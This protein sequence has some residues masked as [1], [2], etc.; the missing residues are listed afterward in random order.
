MDPLKEGGERS[1]LTATLSRRNAL[2]AGAW[3]TP[4]VAAALAV[5]LAAASNDF[6]LTTDL[7]VRAAG[8]AEGRYSTSADY[9]SGSVAPNND[10]RRA[11]SVQNTGMGTFTGTL[12]VSFQFPRMWNNFGVGNGDAFNN[13]GTVDLGSSGGAGVGGAS[14]WSTSPAGS[15]TQNSGAN[16]DTSVWLRMDGASTTLTGVTLP[17]GG[18][19]WF[20]LNGTVPQSWIGDEGVYL[21]G[22]RI[23]WRSDIFISAT[24]STGVSLGTF[25]PVP[26]P[27]TASNWRDGIWY[28]NGG[29][30]FAY[31]DAVTGLYPGYGEG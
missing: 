11:F 29:G 8:G 31:H 15:Y 7:L 19:I 18:T 4:I 14:A 26:D 9:V 23:Y 1:L 30:P 6:E 5:P 16:A 2:K 13:Y 22:G 3:S 20:A 12:T 28:W 24:T 21:P 10:F 27:D 17:P 25:G